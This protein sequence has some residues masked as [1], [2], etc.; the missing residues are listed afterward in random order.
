MQMFNTYS[1]ADRPPVQS[2]TQH[3]NYCF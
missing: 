1:K 2:T 3:Q